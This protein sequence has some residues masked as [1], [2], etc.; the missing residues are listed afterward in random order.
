[1]KA[2][3]VPRGPSAVQ[4]GRP[5]EEVMLIGVPVIIIRMRT[6]ESLMTTPSLKTMRWGISS[7][8]RVM[9]GRGGDGQSAR[10]EQWSDSM[11]R[12]L[13]W[14]IVQEGSISLLVCPPQNL[15]FC[16][17]PQEAAD[18]FGD[19]DQLMKVWEDTRAVN[20]TSDPM[21]GIEEELR[22]GAAIVEVLDVQE[23]LD[24]AIE[25]T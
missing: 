14:G 1:M 16:P 22:E 19:V 3:A 15:Y 18:I 25:R 23:T 24:L 2:S 8:T 21:A 13:R 7:W 11:H 20:R 5:V 6:W 10:R 12:P 17:K 9:R 4:D